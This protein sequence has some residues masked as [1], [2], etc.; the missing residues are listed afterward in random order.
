MMAPNRRYELS[1]EFRTPSLSDLHRLTG[2]Y[3]PVVP[4][5]KWSQEWDTSRSNNCT[6]QHPSWQ[7][8]WELQ[9]TL[10]GVGLEVRLDRLLARNRSWRSMRKGKKETSLLRARRGS[11]CR[12]FG[13]EVS[14]S[15][16]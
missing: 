13:K 11:N 14:Y 12:S 9:V 6:G 3:H 2:H 5:S 16:R 4:L 15:T 8:A 1:T 10:K 7:Q